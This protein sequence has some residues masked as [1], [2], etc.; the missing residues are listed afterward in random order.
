[1]S[2]QFNE[3]Q[4]VLSMGESYESISECGSCILTM[5][6]VNRTN[7]F[8]GIARYLE[9]ARIHLTGPRWFRNFLLPT[10]LIQQFERAEQ[11]GEVQ[12][13][14]LTMKRMMKYFFFAGHAQYAHYITYS[15]FPNF[16]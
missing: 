5:I 13:K 14:Q 3:E 11:K 9:T 1:M 4:V 2:L 16:L 15:C 7:T 6:S 10:L 12:L 8:D